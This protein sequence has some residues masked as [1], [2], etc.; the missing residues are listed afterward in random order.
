MP[1][2]GANDMAPASLALTNSLIAFG[3]LMLA[4]L[5]LRKDPIRPASAARILG[6]STAK[7][8]A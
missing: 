4:R 8:A 6:S 2:F 1:H 7:G 3:S 5:V